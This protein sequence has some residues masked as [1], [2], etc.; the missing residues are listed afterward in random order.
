MEALLQ[1]HINFEVTDKIASDF[2]SASN[3]QLQLKRNSCED[4]DYAKDRIRG[5][6]SAAVFAVATMHF[7]TA[8][9]NRSYNCDTSGSGRQ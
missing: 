5:Y 9:Q 6:Q 7:A 3:M 2:F 1:Q 8:K 4:L